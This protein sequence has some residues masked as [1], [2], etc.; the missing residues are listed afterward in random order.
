[1]KIK[2]EVE[3][4][5]CELIK[6]AWE[7]NVKSKKVHVKGRGYEIRFDF[8]GDICFERGYITTTDIFEVEIEVDEEITEETVI[9]NLLEVYKNDGVIDSVNWKYMS[10]KE[11]LKEDGEQGI[12][13]KMFYML[14]D[15]GTLTLIWKDGELV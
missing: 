3:M 12:T 6:W 8:A 15:D 13:A 11:V 7:Y 2:K 14:H 10:I 4:D 1:M 5:F 9:P